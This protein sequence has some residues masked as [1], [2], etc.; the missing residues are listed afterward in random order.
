MTWFEEAGGGSLDVLVA[1]ARGR[2][3]DKWMEVVPGV[4]PSQPQASIGPPE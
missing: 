1:M 3:L 2:R 4:T